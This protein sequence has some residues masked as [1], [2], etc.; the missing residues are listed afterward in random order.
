MIYNAQGEEVSTLVDCWMSAGEY[1]VRFD[2]Q[3]MASGVYFY[4]F[5]SGSFTRVKKMLFIK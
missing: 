2:A 5:S 1:S 3:D 4:R